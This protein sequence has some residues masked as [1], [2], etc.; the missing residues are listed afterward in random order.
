MFAILK[1]S[2]RC[3]SHAT[4]ISYVVHRRTRLCYAQIWQESSMIVGVLVVVM[5]RVAGSGWDWK[6]KTVEFS[7]LW[8]RMR[9]HIRPK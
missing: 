9:T 2:L 3:S 4:S 1:L 7:S 5:E 6:K 8:Q